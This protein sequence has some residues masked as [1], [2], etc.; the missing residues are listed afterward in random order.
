MSTAKVFYD[1]DVELRH[2]NSPLKREV[3]TK[4]IYLPIY[5][6]VCANSRLRVD[7]GVQVRGN[8]FLN[9]RGVLRYSAE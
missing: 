6:C 7:D 5:S 8:V 4:G 3:V 9:Q 1:N 2:D